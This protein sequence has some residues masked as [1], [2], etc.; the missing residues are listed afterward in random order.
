MKECILAVLDEIVSDDKIKTSVTH[1][2]QQIPMSDTSTI[3]R[4]EILGTEVFESLIE[5]IKQAEFLSIAIDEST[6]NTDVAQL[7]LYVR[8]FDR[9]CFC[10]ELLALIALENFTTGEVISDKI[11]LFFTKNGLDLTK[12]CLLV[13]NGAPSMLGK[14]QGVTA[15]LSAV[16]LQMQC[17][18]VLSIKVF[19]AAH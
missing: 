17:C 15:R 7:C 8:F 12:I 16:A 2:V 5:S 19:C 1:S 13:T 18:I 3:R 9:K 6:D 10:E 11:K 4:I 14:H